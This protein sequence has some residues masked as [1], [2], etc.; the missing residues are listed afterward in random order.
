MFFFKNLLFFYEIVCQ[1]CRVKQKEFLLSQFCSQDIR[2]AI[3]L[4]N[5]IGFLSQWIVLNYGIDVW[6]LSKIM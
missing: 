3:A 1:L 4:D 6:T 5:I 2:F